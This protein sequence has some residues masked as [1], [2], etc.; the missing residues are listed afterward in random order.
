MGAFL[1]RIR[2]RSYLLM[3]LVPLTLLP[4]L[5]LAGLLHLLIQVSFSEEV[6]R[7]ARPEIA[8]LARNLDTLE[9]RLVRQLGGLSR[10]DDMKLAVLTAD[11]SRLR[12][13]VKPWIET[14]L[15]D[16]LKIFN[17]RGTLIGAIQRKVTSE[18]GAPWNQLFSLPEMRGERGPASKGSA[19]LAITAENFVQSDSRQSASALKSAFRDFLKR[20]GGWTLRQIR[21]ETDESGFAFHVFRSLLD[22]DGKVAGYIEGI[23]RMDSLK[24]KHLGLFQGVEF[25]LVGPDRKVLSASLVGSADFFA[26]ELATWKALETASETS[27]PSRSIEVQDIPYEFFF[28]PIVGENNQTEAWIGVGLSRAQHVFLQNRILIWVVGLTL[29]LSLIVIAFSFL[30]SERLTLPIRHLVRAAEDVRAGQA[31]EPFH[32]EATQEISYLVER[33]NEMAMSVQA[34]KR[35]L[36]TKLEEL[37]DTNIQLTQMQDQLVQSAKMSSLGQL[38]AGVAHELNNPIAFIYSNMVQ[39]RQ[40]LKNL[41]E[42][43]ALLDELQKK[44]SDEDRV[45]I[46]SALEKIEW[47]YVKGDMADIVQSCLEG[48]VRVKDIVLGLRNFSRLDKGEVSDADINAALKNTAK[49]LAGQIKNRIRLDWALCAESLL[50]CNI[51]QVN[52]VFMNIMANAIQAI[53]GNGDL[54]VETENVEWQGGKFL[55]V[56]IRDTGQGMPPDVVNKIFDPFFTTKSVGHG[57]GLGLSIVYGIVQKHGGFIDVKS[58]QFPDPMH[59]STFDIYLPKEGTGRGDGLEEAS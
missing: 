29:V 36:E 39:M 18:L 20:E 37:A 7:R 42:L 45:K 12:S 15:F 50:R 34:A 57:T 4:L 59:G 1:S 41:E 28:A 40:Y 22:S 19:S 16:E 44:L 9:K 49:L 10:S 53:E 54:F 58:V 32:V 56:R 2:L 48:S 3:V 31:V 21:S 11:A 25:L 38:V 47:N 6:G 14:S 33:F 17:H 52:Q 24:W 27:L 35:T 13:R 46:Q 23:L 8:A 55:R 51:S 30:F 5:V 26:P 43:T